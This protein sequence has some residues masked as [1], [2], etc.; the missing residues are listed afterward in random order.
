MVDK[1]TL[2]IGIA[3][4]KNIFDKTL[5]NLEE[6]KARNGKILVI[7]Q[8]ENENSQDVADDIFILPECNQIFIPLLANIYLQ[9][10]AYYV[11]KNLGRDIDKPK[12]LAK[13]VTVE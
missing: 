1:N 4:Q 13:S 12:N 11:A 2:I 5:S 7:T 6:C 8:Y 10:F 3:T 9:L